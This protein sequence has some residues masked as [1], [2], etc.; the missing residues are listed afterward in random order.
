MIVDR[1]PVLTYS[2]YLALNEILTAQRPRSTEHD[3][4]LFIVAHQAHELWFKQL[5]YEFAG[6]QRHLAVGDTAHALRTLRR[7][8]GILKAAICQ[9]DVMETITPLRF[10]GCRGD[11]GAADGFQSAQFREVEAVLGR[12][13]HQ[14]HHSY[15]EGSGERH[16]VETAMNRPSIFDSF[17][18]YLT[19]Q[20]YQVPHEL[21]YR[22]V[23]LP[24][25]P[26]AELRAVLLRVYRDDDVTAQ[27]C[28]GLVD[29]DQ[30]AQEWR[31]RHGKTVERIMGDSSDAVRPH[32]TSFTPIFPDLWTVR[33]Q[34]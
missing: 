3:E 23:S 14:A 21:L 17:L 31:Y 1:S 10:T 18:G 25:A 19:A 11:L 7:S 13:D 15:P 20:G 6:L 12:R 2:S 27:I 28:E 9:I 32:P 4:M 22:D 29:L 34:V 5:L 16:Q 33:S 26:S 30:R 24:P 8:L